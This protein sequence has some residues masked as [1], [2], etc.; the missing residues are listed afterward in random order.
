MRIGIGTSRKTIVGKKK[1][2]DRSGIG[3]EI[4]GTVRSSSIVGRR[5]LSFPLSETALSATVMIGTI[6]PIGVIMMMIDD[7]MGQS[8]EGRQFMIGWGA[9]LA[10]TIGLVTVSSIFPGTRKSSRRWLMHGFPM[11]SYFAEMLTRI[12][13]SQG[14]TDARQQGKSYFLHGVL[15]D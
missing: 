1:D 2:A 11:S 12:V 6:G 10:F 13:W 15:K 9:G 8:E 5:I 3:I 4:I 14:R 7:L